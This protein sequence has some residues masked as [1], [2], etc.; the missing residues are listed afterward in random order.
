MSSNPV[1]PAGAPAASVAA[2]TAAAPKAP[3]K[4]L[5]AI[6]IIEQEIVNFFKQRE[7]AI[8]NVHAVDGAIQASQSLLARLKV[9]EAKAVAV[10][11]TDAKAAV[12][13]VEKVSGEVGGFLKAEEG[14]VVLDVKKVAAALEADAKKL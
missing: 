10:A 14:K 11:Q 5:S 7:Q 1:S 12:A 9:E 2:P 3:A 8:A 13:E 4:P 6:Q